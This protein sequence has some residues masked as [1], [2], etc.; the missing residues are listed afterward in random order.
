MS[1]KKKDE[2][3]RRKEG[4]R[5]KEEEEGRRTAYIKSNNPHLTGGEKVVDF[6]QVLEGW[7]VA[8]RT[9]SSRRS[10]SILDVSTN[11]AIGQSI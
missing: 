1:A 7:A 2:G 8:V 6:D 4:E 5:R 9:P 11:R 10:R 3:G